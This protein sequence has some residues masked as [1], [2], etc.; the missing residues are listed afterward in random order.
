M[1]R[2]IVACLQPDTV[3]ARRVQGSVTQSGSHLRAEFGDKPW[4][5]MFA[6]R[7]DEDVLNLVLVEHVLHKE[8]GH[9]DVVVVV[10]G[11]PAPEVVLKGS[12][13]RTWSWQPAL[14]ERG[15]DLRKETVD[16][17]LRREN[18]QLA[19]GVCKLELYL[20][21][22]EH[23]SDRHGHH[24][25]GW[26]HRLDPVGMVMTADPSRRRTGEDD[27]LRIAEVV[28][29]FQLREG[30]FEIQVTCE[31]KKVRVD[32]RVRACVRISSA[33]RKN[34][35][36]EVPE[37]VQGSVVGDH[38]EGSKGLIPARRGSQPGRTPQGAVDQRDT[39]ATTLKVDHPVLR[40]RRA[41]GRGAKVVCVR[42]TVQTSGFIKAR[43]QPET[44]QRVTV[45]RQDL[46]VIH[47]LIQLL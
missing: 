16:V 10:R 13:R 8:R 45:R 39:H 23:P 40:M 32:S 9:L 6:I 14:P 24:L 42:C 26:Q 38:V 11:L 15:D 12:L 31:K 30:S 34:H 29:T 19:Q 18:V 27:I 36:I 44:F 21:W 3:A 5:P 7:A 47:R 33:V 2:V 22:E 37:G 41:R 25:G 17:D 1:P 43:I 20:S 4:S 35:V 46:L 28:L